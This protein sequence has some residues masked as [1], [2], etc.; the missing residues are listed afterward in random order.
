MLVKT[1]RQ[2][3]MFRLPCRAVFGRESSRGV[4]EANK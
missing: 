1:A 2:M 4:F 3:E